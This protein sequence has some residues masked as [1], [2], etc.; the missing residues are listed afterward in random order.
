VEHIETLRKTLEI[1][2]NDRVTWLNGLVTC[3]V[4]ALAPGAAMFGLLVSRTGKIQSDVWLLSQGESLY[5]SLL[6]TRIDAVKA[7]LDAHLIMEDAEILDCE[8]TSRICSRASRSSNAQ[9][10]AAFQWG[11]W[12]L[13][14]EIGTQLDP[15]DAAF[16]QLRFRHGMP[17]FG[18]EVDTAMHPHE[19]SLE[20]VAVSFSKGCYLGQEVVCMVELRGQASRI[21]TR[22]RLARAAAPGALVRTV[23]GAAVGSIRGVWDGTTEVLGF[24]LLKRAAMIPGSAL[25]I[26]AETG[27]TATSATVLGAGPV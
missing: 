1:R 17:L 26:D 20:T 25:L 22:V 23:D 11:S 2:G 8:L 6:A 21:L 13:V 27:G 3:D 7:H 14:L 19:A 5:I 15:A 4:A 12:A 9:M 24:A 16:E 18:V 10:S